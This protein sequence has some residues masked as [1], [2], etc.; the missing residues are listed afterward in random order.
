MTTRKVALS[1]GTPLIW[2]RAR[3]SHANRA[4]NSSAHTIYPITGCCATSTSSS[5]RRTGSGLSPWARRHLALTGTGVAMSPFHPLRDRSD[6]PGA[7]PADEKGSCFWTGPRRFVTVG[8]LARPERRDGHVEL[9][10][11]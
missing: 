9:V 4:P 2:L 7:R 8:S 6:A 11:H 10:Q 5:P 1:V 3:P